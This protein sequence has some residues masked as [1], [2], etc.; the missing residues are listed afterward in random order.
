MSVLNSTG[1]I[2]TVSSIQST[3]SSLEGDR[4]KNKVMQK[5][6]LV[7]T[8]ACAAL[9]LIPPLR[10]AGSLALRGVA[11]LSSILNSK[12]NWEQSDLISRITGCF[13]IALVSLG[14]VALAAASPILLVATLAADIGVQSIEMM[15]CLQKGEYSKALTYFGVIVIDTLA[16]GSIVTGSWQVMAVAVSVSATAML[17]LAFGTWFNAKEDSDKIDIVCY[18]ALH[19]IVLASFATI[20]ELKPKEVQT[21][22]ANYDERRFFDAEG[23]RVGF[24]SKRICT[25]KFYNDGSEV[26][27]PEHAQW[28]TQIASPSAAKELLSTVPVSG[29]AMVTKELK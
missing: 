15:R 8:V 17:A 3:Q 11:L 1:G 12:Y 25:I 2:S 26:L 10:V 20:D 29:T 13:K 19:I 28:E 27:V 7:L 22:P 4:F 16:L 5:S 23:N 24:L 6:L 14:I 18:I 9:S 21:K